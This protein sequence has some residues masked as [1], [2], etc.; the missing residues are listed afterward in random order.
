VI[1]VRVRIFRILIEAV[2]ALVL[3]AALSWLR[4]GDYLGL[5]LYYLVL[6]MIILFIAGYILWQFMRQNPLSAEE[7]YEQ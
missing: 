1:A 2:I 6:G 3:G 7:P 5:S 4:I